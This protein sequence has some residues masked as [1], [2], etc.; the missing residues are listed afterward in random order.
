MAYVK[1]YVALLRGVNVGR[2]NRL[3]MADVRELVAELGYLAP[4]TLLN[5]GNVVFSGPDVPTPDIAVQ[6]QE[7]LVARLGLSTR[8][9]VLTAE[10]LSAVIAE[11]P[12]SAAEPSRLLLGFLAADA[13]R[14]SLQEIEGRDWSP[15]AIVLGEHAV[16]LWCPN[17][18]AHSPMLDSVSRAARESITTRNWTTALKLQSMLGQTQ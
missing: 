15:E 4:R 1:Q 5:S 14:A 6:L 13:D 12:L 10:D 2:G 3:A 11:N 7:A 9:I 8:V 18:V 17:G 16:Y